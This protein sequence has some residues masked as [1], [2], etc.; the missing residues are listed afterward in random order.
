M[1][2]LAIAIL[3]AA[4]VLLVAACGGG[5]ATSE[6]QALR[7]GHGG[8]PGDILTQS[9]EHF[10]E[11]VEEGTDGRWTVENYGASQLGNERDLV[12]GVSLGTVDMT[13]VTNS[14]IGNFVPEA[15]FYDLPGLYQ[16]LD[17]VHAVAES[18]IITDHFAPAL[19]ES[20]LRLLGITD[21]GFRNITNS[22]RE[23]HS[24]DDLNGIKMRVQ[25]SPMIMATYEAIPG[26]S[27]VPVPIGDLYTALDQGV[28]DAQ[29]NPAIL[30]RDFKF[31]EVQDYMTITGHSY[32]PR[33][34]LINET[35]WSSMSD[36]DQQVFR[37]AAEEMVDFK[38]DYYASET[39]TALA[40]LE[41]SGMQITEPDASF[42]TELGE[43]MQA[44]VYPEFYDEIGG[45]D[46][47]KGEQIVQ[48]I[49]D[50]AG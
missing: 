25:E 50:L 9:V 41:E 43:L 36:E 29:E 21:G 20:D 22:T 1:K 12:E 2:R 24:L 14:P 48:Q 16:D 45:G 32:F 4:P 33:H 30:V 5:G 40:E 49:I 31:Y 46:A 38:N 17:H 28:V 42:K 34:L 6:G 8:A 44:E 19:L 13:L 26:V 11:L 7:L 35:I 18:T 3:T 37:D 10:N 39:E 15:L 23:V 27:P 47:A